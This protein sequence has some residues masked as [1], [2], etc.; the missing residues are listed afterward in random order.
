MLNI[1]LNTLNPQAET[2][3]INF[4]IERS[5][6]E[7]FNLRIPCEKH[8]QYQQ[9]LYHVSIGFKKV[10]DSIIGHHEVEHSTNKV[11]LA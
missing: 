5:I 2:I 7:I 9:E 10:F 1:L 11:N 8:L 4:R 6:I 3:I